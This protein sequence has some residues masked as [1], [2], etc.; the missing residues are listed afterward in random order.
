MTGIPHE[1]GHPY[2]WATV[3]APFFQDPLFQFLTGVN[4]VHCAVFV[5]EARGKHVLFVPKKDLKKEFW[6]GARLGCGSTEAEQ[7]VLRLTG[8][9]IGD[10]DQLN[11][12]VSDYLVE[13]HLPEVSV[14]WHEPKADQPAIKDHHTAFRLSLTEQ[15]YERSWKGTVTNLAPF[16]WPIRLCL[17]SVDL[18]LF[19]KANRLTLEAMAETVR[20]LPNLKSELE[21]S[22]ILH[23]ELLKR[24]SKGL[25]FYPIVAAG[26]NAAVLH[27]HN[28][29]A[30]LPPNSL[31][32]IDCGLRFHSMP[33]DIT[34]TYPISGA[35]NPLQAIL[36][37]IVEDT[38]K[39]VESSI[40]EGVTIAQLNEVCWT[41][42]DRLLDERFLSKGGK[43]LREYE[44]APHNVSHLI[45][46]AVHDGDPYR[47]YRDMPLKAGMVISNEPGL[48]G[49]FEMRIGSV[50][51]TEH[52]G[53][54]I[55]D[56]IVVSR[57]GAGNLT[58]G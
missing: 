3:H 55:E 4:Q 23:G 47:N 18:D 5:D 1:L 12:F 8:L 57:L 26:E 56:D 22:G 50:E 25:S 27:Y 43:M 19:R 10:I 49:Q 54:R 46:L 28:N 35:M 17:D 39:A 42:M 33:A 58:R 29:D 44:K 32:L 52:V 51:Y 9:D 53:I 11:T 24:T 13:H 6:D 16:Q 37:G 15:L 7:D 38:Q 40:K 41:T 2:P 34:R 45:G 30:P 20:Q 48:Y 21:V 14:F 36:H 31:L